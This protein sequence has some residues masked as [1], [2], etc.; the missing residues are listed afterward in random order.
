MPARE[1]RAPQSVSFDEHRWYTIVTVVDRFGFT[2]RFKI[3]DAD[4]DGCYLTEIDE[5]GDDLPERY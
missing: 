1:F 4:G 3:G 5:H 2:R